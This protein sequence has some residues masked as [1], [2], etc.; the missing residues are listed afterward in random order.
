MAQL[1]AVE[2]A[3]KTTAVQSCHTT[4]CSGDN[5]FCWC[6]HAH[7]KSFL[8]CTFEQIPLAGTLIQL[9]GDLSG[10][11]FWFTL[12]VSCRDQHQLDLNEPSALVT[13]WSPQIPTGVSPV[14]SL[15]EWWVASVFWQQGQLQFFA[16]SVSCPL[17]NFVPNPNVKHI[18]MNC[19]L[20]QKRLA[21]WT[22]MYI[23]SKF[24]LFEGQTLAPGR[25]S[26]RFWE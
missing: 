3:Q 8:M 17:F 16:G 5:Y 20:K 24:P 12:W 26:I 15:N 11:G 2:I 23:G 6:E 25:V 1:D 22:L 18:I 9:M 10:K 19:V 13:F 21:T 4:S 7:F 14:K